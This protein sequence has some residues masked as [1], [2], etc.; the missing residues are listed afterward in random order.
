[1]YPQRKIIVL[2]LLTF[3][4]LALFSTLPFNSPLIK[5][6]KATE[7]FASDF[8]GGTTG[9]WTSEQKGTGDT[10]T[11]QSSIKKNGTYAVNMTIDDARTQNGFLT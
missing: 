5:E 9:E 6:V 3:L 11:V 8:E 10:I 4:F 7:I 1:M 2:T